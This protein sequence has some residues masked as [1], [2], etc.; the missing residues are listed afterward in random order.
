M[1]TEWNTLITSGAYV[2]EE[3]QAEFGRIPPAFLPIGA[4]FVVQHQLTQIAGRK[5]KW[6][7]LPKDYEISA[8]QLR[9]LSDSNVRVISSDPK[10]SL[11]L[12]VFHSI[13]EIGPDRP[14]EILHG[15]TL[16]LS[17]NAPATDAFST[18]DVTE[19]YRWGLVESSADVVTGVRDADPTDSLTTTSKILSGYFAIS[20]PWRFLKCL[21]ARDFSF[22]QALDAYC[23]EAPVQALT[24]LQTL[25]CGHLKTYY[26]SRR[27]LASARHFNDLG[28]ESGVVRKRSQDARKID[29]EAN[30]LRSVPP[31]LQPFTVRLIESA[32]ATTPGEYRTLYSSYPT[33][34]ELYLAR[35]SRFVW[36]RVLDSCIEYLNLA[37]RHVAPAR[38]SSF[39]WLVAGKLRERMAQYPTML[40]APGEALT[41]NGQKAGTLNSIAEHLAHEIASAPVLPACVM[42]GD[43]CFS[44]MLFDLRSDRIQLIDPR[45]LIGPETTIYGDIRYDIAKLGHSVVGRYDQILGEKLRASG[46]G[47]DFHLAVPRDDLRDWLEEQFLGSE[48]AGVSFRERAVMAAMVSLFLSMIPLHA[49]DPARQR[50]LLANGLRLYARFFGQAGP[51]AMAGKV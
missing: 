22:T 45:G 33:V 8:P 38:G 46:S 13:L 4:A 20:D 1:A 32:G 10:K 28:V 14:L 24:Q 36:R 44:N 50:A 15:D 31:D 34:A 9:I 47:A 43:F 5:N 7:S 49:D 25:D 27:S 19:Q 17:P 11:G 29:A 51:S 16:V 41:I 42:H 23:K 39:D 21:A 35:S 3:M 48:A 30:W 2:G 37:S 6:L 40:P 18:A 26:A 12:A